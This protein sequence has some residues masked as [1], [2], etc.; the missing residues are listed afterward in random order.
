MFVHLGLFA[1]SSSVMKGPG[2][3]VAYVICKCLATVLTWNAVHAVLL[4]PVVSIGN[5][6][7]KN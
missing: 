4:R 5:S 2:L 1:L 6:K 3:L 7:L